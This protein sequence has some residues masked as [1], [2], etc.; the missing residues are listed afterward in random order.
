[1]TYYKKKEIP[2]VESRIFLHDHQTS[3]EPLAVERKVLQLL[4][5][6]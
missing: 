5:G 3:V 4:Q 2:L 6:W 1:M